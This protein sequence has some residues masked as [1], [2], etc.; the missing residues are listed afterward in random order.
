MKFFV[1]RH[2]DKAEGDYFNPQLQHNDQPIS[3]HG[4]EQASNLQNYFQDL[5]VKSIFISEYLRTEQTAQPLASKLG[6]EPIVDGRLNEIDIGIGDKISDDELRESYP[7][8]WNATQDWN[9][10][11]RWPEGETG[12][13]AQERIVSFINEWIDQEE[14]IVIVT[15]DGLIRLLIC[16]I[17][18]LPVF[19][20]TSFHVDTASV[21][22]IE[23]DNAKSR[24][25]LVRFNQCVS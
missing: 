16:Y 24:W 12:A 2:S 1:V 18:G 25:N 8:V 15:H 7:D 9:R 3:T 19:R 5:P 23:W 4:E 14:C 17:L 13:E 6:L 21:S 22:E 10:D 20:R 11:F